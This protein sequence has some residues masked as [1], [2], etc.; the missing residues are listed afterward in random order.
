MSQ[1]IS[2]PGITASSIDGELLWGFWYPALRSDELRGRALVTSMRMEVPL[3]L[4]RD[5]AGK[6]FALR[7]VCPHRAFPLSAGSCDGQTVEC[8]Y[9]G[10]RFD[11]HTGQCREI[12]SIT[13]DSKLQCDRIY[14]GSFPCEERDGY[15]WVYL[16]NPEG[17]A[18]DRAHDGKTIAPVPELPKFSERFRI[19]HLTAD[20]TCSMDTGIVGLM[21]PAHGPFVHQSW[22]WRSR[23]SIR[24]KQKTF[25]PIPQGFR[26]SSHAPSANS[27]PYKLL[28]FYGEEV[29]TQI[30]FVLPNMR[31]EQVRC[32]AYWFTNRTTVTPIRRDLCRLDFVAAW[33]LFR[34]FPVTPFLKFFGKRFIAQDQDVI[35]RQQPGL[36]VQP[37][38]MLIDD[39]DRQARWYF[40]L[41]AAYLASQQTGAPMAHPLDG[42]VT[43]RWRS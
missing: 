22:W 39:A 8:T 24:E 14:A 23:R 30:D 34:W 41:K 20:L 3:V 2:V 10:W 26:M 15:V 9:H 5:A 17:R 11:A 35:E 12:P 38:M 37:R 4:G 21:D 7:D 25:E 42:P 13:A 18:V 19:A 27:G 36:K 40:Q 16:A 1:F 32:G 33:N 31:T 29:T 6:A 28:R 43:L